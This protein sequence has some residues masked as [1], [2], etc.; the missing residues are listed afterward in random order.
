M[1]LSIDTRWRETFQ[2]RCDQHLLAV[3]A[4]VYLMDPGNSWEKLIR[5]TGERDD[6]DHECLITRLLR[7]D[8]Y[9]FNT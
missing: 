8:I 7:R 4:T 3:E 1:R 9:F 2:G 6:I 5:N